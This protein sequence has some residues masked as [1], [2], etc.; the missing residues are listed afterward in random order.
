[1]IALCADHLAL[2]AEVHGLAHGLT[3][4]LPS[5]CLLCGSSL[6][7]RHHDGWTCAV[8]EW[9]HGRVPDADLPP[10][11]V[12]V[13]Y[14][15]R[16]GDRVKIGTTA[17]PRQRFAAIRHERLLAMERGDRGLEQRRHTEFAA[18]RLGTSEW[19]AGSE[20]LLA[21]ADVLAGGVDPWDRWR[22]WIAEA[23]AAR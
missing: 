16:L 9:P 7:V 8:C 17:N 11:R 3:G 10:V 22:R 15:L 13:V 1:M 18:D 20:R 23:S 6:G 2:A 14:Y 4:T 21:H 12:D 19:F 5:P